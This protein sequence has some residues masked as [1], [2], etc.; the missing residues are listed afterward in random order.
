MLGWTHILLGQKVDRE[1]MTR[2]LHVIDRNAVAQARL[3]D[4]MLD[5][6]RIVTGK[7][8]LE[9]APVDLVAAT[10]AAVDVVSPSA[11][12]KNITTDD[13]TAGHMMYLNLPDLKK[14][15]ADLAKFIRGAAGKNP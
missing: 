3:I 9:M 12:A 8:R 13:Y 6:A 2:A 1:M 11:L 4:D 15:K 7:L 10:V 14:Q 5:M